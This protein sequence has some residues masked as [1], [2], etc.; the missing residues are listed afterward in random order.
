MPRRCCRAR[1]SR[2]YLDSPQFWG[3]AFHSP[4]LKGIEAITSI[5]QTPFRSRLCNW[6]SIPLC[7]SMNRFRLF[8]E[9]SHARGKAGRTYLQLKIIRGFGQ[10]HVRV[11]A[12]LLFF[13]FK[14][15]TTF[16]LSQSVVSPRKFSYGW[17]LPM[18]FSHV[19]SN[20]R[21]HHAAAADREHVT[22]RR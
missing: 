11:L 10:I 13:L 16:Q 21:Q 22:R 20:L 9:P 18:A 6:G 7:D 15:K 3:R 17:F 8:T 5:E 14:T 4:N 2:C 19:E 12:Y 1:L